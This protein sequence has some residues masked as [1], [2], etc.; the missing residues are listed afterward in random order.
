MAPGRQVQ[1]LT[2]V[3]AL[4]LAGCG[5]ASSSSSTLTHA[6]LVSK[7]NAVCAQRNAKIAALP[8][9]L[10]HLSTLKDLATYLRALESING[11]LLAQ[12][13]ALK[14]PAS[15]K[16][17]WDDAINDN[18]SIT[19]LITQAKSAAQAGNGAEV[20]R[21]ETELAPINQRL[22]SDAVRLGLTECLK[23]PVPSA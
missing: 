8:K 20:Q 14:P 21:I 13:D 19:L 6:E 17:V 15:D 1:I 4:A 5:G 16:A 22:H 12:L 9:S 3:G 11:P 2:L 18:R 23:Q 10:T 7:A